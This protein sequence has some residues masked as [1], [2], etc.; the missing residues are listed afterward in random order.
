[1]FFQDDKITCLKYNEKWK[2][3]LMK[4]L[5]YSE[6]HDWSCHRWLH[7]YDRMFGG[8]KQSF[9]TCNFP[10]FICIIWPSAYRC[11]W[12]LFDYL[13]SLESRHSASDWRI[14]FPESPEIAQRTLGENGHELFCHWNT[15]SFF[16]ES[17]M[18]RKAHESRNCILKDLPQTSWHSALE[19]LV[20]CLFRAQKTKR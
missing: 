12:M 10:F 8:N 7:F 3:I 9:W 2:I 11:V 15:V 16:K 19:C 20:L 14:L 6:S 13:H 5:S 18:R 1:M 4:L 17:T